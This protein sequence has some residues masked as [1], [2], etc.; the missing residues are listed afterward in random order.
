MKTILLS[1]FILLVKFIFAQNWT[2]QLDYPSTERDDGCSFTI[3]PISYCGSGLA[4]W[5]SP[6]ADFY[7]Y[8]SFDSN[9][10]PIQSL[11]AGKERQ[12]ATAFSHDSKGYVFGGVSS[13]G[14]LND[15]WQ[16]DPALNQWD[17][18]SSLPSEGISGAS[19]FVIGDTAYIIGGKN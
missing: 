13:N 19:S 3:G 16:F 6:L 7:A 10:Y 5:F 11:P 17:S 18:I 12:Y 8:N 4:P 9:W 2:Q 1:F 14:Y 15:L